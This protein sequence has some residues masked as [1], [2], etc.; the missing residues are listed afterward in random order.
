M[1]TLNQESVGIKRSLTIVVGH[2]SCDVDFLLD[3]SPGRAKG[4]G[5]TATMTNAAARSRQA[6]KNKDHLNP[7][8]AEGCYQ[9]DRKQPRS[10]DQASKNGIQEAPSHFTESPESEREDSEHRTASGTDSEPLSK[11]EAT[12]QQRLV[13]R[14]L[15]TKPSEKSHGV[16]NVWDLRG[17]DMCLSTHPALMPYNREF[18]LCNYMVVTDLS[19]PLSADESE[20]LY[21][22]SDGEVIEQTHK[23]SQNADFPLYLLSSIALGHENRGG[24]D[25]W[26]GKEDEE[27]EAPPVFVIGNYSDILRDK[28]RFPDST[29]VHEWLRKQGNF[30][31]KFLEGSDMVKHVICPDTI[32]GEYTDKTPIFREMTHYVKSL[33]LVDS[34]DFSCE[35]PHHI[36]QRVDRMTTKHWQ[37]EKKQPLHWGLL[38]HLFLLWREEMKTVVATIDEIVTLAE[39]VCNFSGREEVITSLKFLDNAG[40]VLYYPDDPELK[41][42]VFTSP[43][44]VFKF[45]SAFFAAAPPGPRMKKHWTD[46]KKKGLMTKELLAYRL[47][48][49]RA[50]TACQDELEV[51]SSREQIRAENELIVRLL[52]LLDIITPVA[53][54]YF[55]PPM[56]RTS[57]PT[58]CLWRPENSCKIRFPAPLIVFP[59]TLKYVPERLYFRLVTSFLRMH[60]KGPRLSRHRCIFLVDDKD[61]SLEGLISM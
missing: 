16:R 43:T 58:S 23:L 1:A 51:D 59:T 4:L 35:T 48:Q 41:D 31:E 34:I 26:L 36:E 7:L 2:P 17:Y 32:T 21:Q 55:V 10:F 18:G 22:S 47:R 8:T 14:F 6:T 12:N 61:L 30:F 54:A 19:K 46:L 53:D 42:V 33:F 52:Q 28:A 24:S 25:H 56:L 5:A 39:A 37:T 60:P 45:L 50:K 44:W 57:L 11:T 13:N 3:N 9:V 27:V 20:F 38:E 49:M 29:A 15:K 40:A